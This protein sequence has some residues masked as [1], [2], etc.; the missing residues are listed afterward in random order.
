NQNNEQKQCPEYE[1]HF[2]SKSHRDTS[3]RVLGALGITICPALQSRSRDRNHFCT[4]PDGD[5][6]ETNT[7]SVVD[8]PRDNARRLPSWDHAIRFERGDLPG[9]ATWHRQIPEVRVLQC[10][11]ERQGLAIGRPL[12]DGNSDLGYKR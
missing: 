9:S 12:N 3:R 10:F 2:R 7:T 6:W 5:G 11:D 1:L 4:A 8:V